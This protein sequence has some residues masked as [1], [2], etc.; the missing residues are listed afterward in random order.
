MAADSGTPPVKPVSFYKEIRPILQAQCQ[1]CHQP[2]KA[3]G[4]YV[5][6]EF[7]KMFEPGDSKEKPIVPKQPDASL[8][9]KQITPVKGEA[10]MPKGKPALPEVDVA[11]I[12]QWITEGATDDTPANARQR[13]DSEHPP[14]YTRPPVITSIDYSKDGRW[15][16]VSGFHEVLLHKADGS[17]LAGRL[18]GM[19]DRIQSVRFSPDGKQLAVAGGQPGRLG[20]IQI[21]DVEKRKLLVSAP[22]GYD[23]LYG[24]NW[25]PDGK[26]VSF[27]CPDK[28]VRAVEAATG[29][30]ILQQGSHNDWVLD[31]VFS[32]NGTHVISVGRD[33]SVKLT[34]VASQR[35]IDNLTSITPGALRGGVQSV[36]RHPNRDEVLIGGADGVP[37]IYRVVRV[38]ARKIG[39]NANLIRRFPAMEGRIF[40]VG[41]SPDGKRIAAGASLDG[42]GEVHVYSSDFDSTLPASL[43]PIL[44]KE[45]AAHSADE[46][47]AVEKYVT[48]DVK[49]VSSVTFSN[50]SVYA[51]CFSPDGQQLAAAGSDGQIR[52]VDPVSG[53]VVKV[54]GAAP[55]LEPAAD[56]ATAVA[57]VDAV[58]KTESSKESVHESLPKGAE[59]A[60]LSVQ[61]GEI[62]LRNRT[63]HVQVIV[64]AKLAS[65]DEIDVTRMSRY[66]AADGLAAVS[67]SGKLTA[68]KS[69]TGALTVSF[70]GK[71]ASVPIELSSF[72]PEFSSDFV[73]D[74]GP[75]LSKLGCNAGTCHG[76]KEGKNGFKL[77]LRGYDPIYDV[78]SF[79]DD[80][81]SRRVALASPDDSLILLKA[82]GAVP[83]EGGQRT[84]TDSEYYAILRQWI[85]RGAALQTQSPRVSRIEVFPKDPVVQETGSKQQMRIV[86]TYADGKTRD[87][88]AEAFIESG[89][90]DV[91]TAN[92]TGLIT[93]LRRGEAPILARYEGSYAATIL[94][95]MGDRSGFTWKEPPVHNRIDE[96]VAA[97]WKRM[98]ILPSELASDSEFVRRVYLDLTGLP[99]SP[100]QLRKFLRDRGDQRAKRDELI[101]RL[102]GSPEFVDHWA[103]K[104]ADLLQVNRKF[105]GEEGAR[106][107]R[108]WIHDRIQ[109]N[110]PYDEFV[111]SILTSSGS[112][113]ENPAAS[114]YK[115]LRTPAETMENTTHLFLATRFNCNKCH[116]H[117]FE[118]WTQ[119]QY[120]QMT[121]FFA[122]VDL[123]ND[124]A[125][126]DRRI[127]GSAVEGAKPLYEV[128]LDKKQGEVKHDRTGKVTAPQFPFPAKMEGCGPEA[129]RRQ[130]LAAW[131]TS[132]DNR[133]FALSFVNRLWGYLLG[134]GLID[135][136]DDIRAGNPAS[137]PALL[138]YLTQQFVDSG[139]NTRRILRLICQSRTYQLSVSTHEWNADDKVNYSHAM[140]RRLPAEV[141][142]DAVYRVTG[143]T[144]NVPGAKLGTRAAQ[145]LDSSS[146]VP[147]GFLATLGRP[148]RESACECERSNDIRL[149]SVMSLLS[150]PAVS[151]AVNDPKNALAKLVDDIHDDAALI[152]EVFIRVLNREASEH[153]IQ[154]ALKLADSVDAEHS[155]LSQELAAAETAWKETRAR[156]DQE[157]SQ[158][159]HQAEQELSAYLVDQ[160]PKFALANREREDR[161]A[162]AEEAIA[163]FQPLIPG[164]LNDWESRLGP[165]HWNT[166]WVP[167]DPKELKGSGS[168]KLEKLPDGSVRSLGSN[169]ELNDYIVTAEIGLAGITGVKLEVLP[170]DSLPQFGPGF[171]DGNFLLSEI[172]VEAGSKT[173]A[174]SMTRLKITDAKADYIQKDHDL[175]HT[176]DGRAEQGRREGWAIGDGGAGQRHWATFALEKPVGTAEGS[177]L[178][179]TLQHR[180]QSPYDIGR[181]RIW[182]TTSP[183]P[184]D[185]GLPAD[186]GEISKISALLRAPGQAARMQDYFRSIDPE[187]KKREQALFVAKRPLPEDDKV[188]EL[189]MN[190]ATA[191][192]PV[193]TDPALIQL[194]LDVQASEKQRANKRLTVVQDLTWALINT[195][196]FLF[197][198]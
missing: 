145:L 62:R 102:I 33:M 185:E 117:P 115:I 140:A 64:S 175:K 28:T 179:I 168:T 50:V 73:Q 169:G 166:A 9:V 162:K 10:E 46:R 14:K 56:P 70:A 41:Y 98:K 39:D 95:V 58:A 141:L 122:Q 173:N 104:W 29:K 93:T 149:G 57:P 181:F 148:P 63:E 192:K 165:E 142:M 147:S 13:Y 74:V 34:E 72:Q 69:G 174:S 94:T 152:R 79:A 191:S 196:S 126:G 40:S 161:I 52:I 27:G 86:A 82:T 159:I 16:A 76:A 186:V 150:G 170:D 90:G 108:D 68:L 134:V 177:S 110:T 143:S 44:E 116:D 190:L 111:R 121:A 65:G 77:S 184:T 135:P 67:S 128:V 3:K 156:K 22:V 120:Y 85:S 193:P 45:T 183:R 55:A 30:Q 36:A 157:R 61:P 119:D 114:Y 66:E 189:K 136:L 107:F 112:N 127:G 124:P 182:V 187:L 194:R 20:E 51:V 42:H 18:V 133:Y 172:I 12:R 26:W 84:T 137:N 81:G 54:F 78:R 195:P 198:R 11:K 97:K 146:D 109:E 37:Q 188:K 15:L 35:F 167:L 24:A 80:L 101:D 53:A 103:N 130:K 5:L 99:P 154:A 2:A 125:S 176:F 180:Y 8:L 160:A 158:R 118:R 164:R 171:K 144:L 139:F 6:T 59:V 123:Q 31:T 138:E 105:L 92:G 153:D 21:W 19:S 132:G 100:E 75:V 43:I 113:R 163:D 178:R 155:K 60:S 38:T 23:T 96:L 32:T 151:G 25:S 83:H 17:G 48:A 91:A 88:T 4:G 106:L 197:N 131:M 89:N 1:G 71:S 47:A 7:D 87:V 49:L 129:T